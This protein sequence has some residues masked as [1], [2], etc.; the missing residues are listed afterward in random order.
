MRSFTVPLKPRNCNPYAIF[1]SWCSNLR[2]YLVSISICHPGFSIIILVE[3][4]AAAE[5]SGAA[6]W[7]HEAC[8]Y[9]LLTLWLLC[10]THGSSMLHSHCL[11]LCLLFP[12]LAPTLFSPST[13]ISSLYFFSFSPCFLTP[14]LCEF[15]SFSMT[16]FFP[17]TLPSW[18]PRSVSFPPSFPS[19]S[20]HCLQSLPA[21]CLFLPE[22]LAY[23]SAM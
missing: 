7:K 18:P 21:L 11:P 17:S 23:V 12:S 5:W 1:Y 22:P 14:T 9:W 8:C 15:L 3:S 16:P 13:P 2:Q 19:S 6:D 20:F 10:V 4:E